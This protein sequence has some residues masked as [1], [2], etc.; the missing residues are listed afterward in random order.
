M[1][2]KYCAYCGKELTSAQRNNTYCSQTCANLAKS[3]NKINDWLTGAISGLDAGGNLSKVIRNYLIERAGQKC[4]LCGWHAINPVTQKVPLEIHHIDGNYLNNNITNLQVLC[5]NC[6]A[7]TPNFKA[8]NNST[9][10][11]TQTRKTYCQDCGKEITWGAIRCKD[12]DSKH[13]VTTK[14]I[15][16]EELK[17]K[18]YTQSFVS[19]GA[20]YGVS[21]NAIRKWCVQYNLPSKKKDIKKYSIEEWANI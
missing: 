14:P 11:R 5:P 3:Q 13:R 18:I 8:L 2:I 6:H 1:T 10:K 20:E 15:T 19:I 4:E 16:R 12:C 7:L 21:D 17:Q 9:R